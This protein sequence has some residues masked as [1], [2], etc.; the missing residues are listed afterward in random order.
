M[1]SWPLQRMAPKVSGLCTPDFNESERAESLFASAVTR[2]HDYKNLF[3]HHRSQTYGYIYIAKIMYLQS[4]CKCV[5]K[6]QSDGHIRIKYIYVITNPSIY[7]YTTH[8]HN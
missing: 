4:K 1:L 8:T 6:I 5:Q 7:I 2:I 3:V